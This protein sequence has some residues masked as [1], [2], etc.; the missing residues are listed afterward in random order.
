MEP[1]LPTEARIASSGGVTLQALWNQ[2]EN[3]VA[4]LVFSHPH[5]EH[6][7]TMSAPLMVAVARALSVRG[8]AVL[9]FNFRG[10]GTST[11]V[12][13]GGDAERDDIAAAVE[14]ALVTY[15]DREPSLAGWSFGAATALRWQARAGSALAFVGVAPPLAPGLV[16]GLPGPGDLAAGDRTILMGD[17]DQFT[18]VTQAK[19]YA[20][21]IDASV[22]IIKG[23]DHFFLFREDRVAAL[24][25][26]GI[27]LPDPGQ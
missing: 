16:A 23:S 1:P 19:R 3:A 4:T 6:G 5:P 20:A 17:R 21:G 7:G 22:E 15:P 9:R 27:G 18:S 2:P 10:V 25:A 8:I 12:H 26:G 24:I 14:L 13:D 11:G